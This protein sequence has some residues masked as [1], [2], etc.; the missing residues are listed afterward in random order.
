MKPTLVCPICQ[1]PLSRNEKSAYCHNHHVFDY[2]KS[3]YLNLYLFNRKNHGDSVESRKARTTFLESDTY[4]FLRDYLS[5]CIQEEGATVLGDLGC[6]EGYYT[7]AFPVETKFGFD[8]SKEALIYAAK[9]DSITSYVLSSIFHIPL[10]DETLDTIVTCFAPVANHEIERLLK[11]DGSFF[12]VTPGPKHL[13]ELKEML[14]EKPYE[15]VIKEIELSIPL[16]K[17]EIISQT[18]ET[19]KQLRYALF[20]MT[21]YAYHTSQKDRDKLLQVDSLTITAEFVIRQYKK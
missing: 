10:A 16:V 8:L 9:H 17:E 14:Y 18:F 7:R 15:N 19:D 5:R 12:L 6:G 4:S 13:F 1:Q 21:P 2:A 11:K 3:G 20:E